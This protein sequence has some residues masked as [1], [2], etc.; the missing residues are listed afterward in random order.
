MPSR[1]EASYHGRAGGCDEVM[2]LLL[3]HVA[4]RHAPTRLLGHPIKGRQ[5]ARLKDLVLGGGASLRRKTRP[6]IGVD[7]RSERLS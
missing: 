3:A 1:D 2:H 5:L 4:E 7:Q 6:T